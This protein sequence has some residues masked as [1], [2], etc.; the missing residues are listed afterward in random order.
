[1]ILV[2]YA[3]SKKPSTGAIRPGAFF[4]TNIFL[5]AQL[6]FI[7]YNQAV[8]DMKEKEALIHG[9]CHFGRKIYT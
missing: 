9:F 3:G 7:V 8:D 5:T 4:I 1:M 2:T 6:Y